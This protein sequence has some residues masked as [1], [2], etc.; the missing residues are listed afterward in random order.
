MKPEPAMGI[1]VADHPQPSAP[2]ANM[3]RV[4][5]NQV[6][7]AQ[8]F[9]TGLCDCCS[10]CSVCKYFFGVIV[11]IFFVRFYSLYKDFAHELRN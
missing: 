8:D 3:S 11:M 10:D 4:P 1:P 9:S 7:F 2:P 5:Q 6:V